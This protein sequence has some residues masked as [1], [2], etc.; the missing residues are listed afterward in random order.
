M[1]LPSATPFLGK[2]RHEDEEHKEHGVLVVF[3]CASSMS[4][5]LCMENI[6]VNLHLN[7]GRPT[8][9][10]YFCLVEGGG[11]LVVVVGF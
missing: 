2:V 10:F 9:C 1:V 7:K 11:I 4:S 3:V 5:G 6:Y 8:R